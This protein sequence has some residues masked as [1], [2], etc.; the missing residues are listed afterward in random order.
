MPHHQAPKNMR[1]H[2]RDVDSRRTGVVDTRPETRQGA[3]LPCGLCATS[4]SATH[5][6]ARHVNTMQRAQAADTLRGAAKR[7]G[8]F[9]LLCTSRPCRK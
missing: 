6:R 1:I 8:S 7:V 9:G 2:A 5:L 3:L 4:F